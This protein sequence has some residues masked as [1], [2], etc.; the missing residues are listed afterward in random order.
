MEREVRGEISASPLRV[1]VRL[2]LKL[3][4][5]SALYKRVAGMGFCNITALVISRLA[6]PPL[7]YEPRKEI[8]TLHCLQR[9]R[10]IVSYWM[11]L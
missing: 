2:P 9:K 8:P 10:K 11:A 1:A 7:S 3:R 5:T 6:G 4:Y